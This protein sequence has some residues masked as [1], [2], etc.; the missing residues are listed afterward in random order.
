VGKTTEE[1]ER[2][3]KE[4]LQ[5]LLTRCSKHDPIEKILSD[6]GLTTVEIRA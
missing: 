1:A 5:L 2:K 6:C 4:D 3:L